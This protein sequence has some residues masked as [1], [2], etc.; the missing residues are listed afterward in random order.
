MKSTTTD[1]E[2]REKAMVRGLDSLDDL[3]LLSLLIAPDKGR[4]AIEVAERILETSGSLATLAATPLA[5]L[6]RMEGLGMERALHL[7]AAAELG[8]RILVAEGQQTT[9][10]QNRNDVVALFAPLIGSLDHEEMWVL[11][12]TSS[13]SIIERRRISIGGSSALT[14]DFKLI[15]RHALNLVASSI[16]VVHNHP[17]GCSEPSE[18]DR[19]F[20]ARLKEAAALLDVQLLD[21][22][23]ISRNSS[24]SFRSSDLL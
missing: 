23:I 12:L 20:T 17:S 1:R 22:I 8:R 10:I 16:I 7:R 9:T 5:E 19:R 4:S 15:L 18:E 6:R 11:Y 13:N 21:H 24:F 2:V 14:T 3:E